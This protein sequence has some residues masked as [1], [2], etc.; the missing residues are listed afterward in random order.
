M[1]DHGNCE[2][3]DAI[4]ATITALLAALERLSETVVTLGGHKT[5][6]LRQAGAAIALAKEES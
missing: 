3:C 4:D 5:E 2:R 6:S 1:H